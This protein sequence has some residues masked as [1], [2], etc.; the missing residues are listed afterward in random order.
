VRHRVALLAVSAA[1]AAI[2]VSSPLAASS[3]L[4]TR[5]AK[6]L[7]SPNLSLER[8]SAIAVDARTGA[9]LFAHNESAPVVPASNE[10]LPVAWAALTRLGPSYRF[11]TQVLGVGERV[12]TTWDG[13]LYLRGS[14]DPTLAAGDIGRLAA[15]VRAAGIRRVTGRI[16]GDESAFDTMR[17]VAGW[18]RY[19]V[20]LESPP[21]SALVVDRA[22]GWPGHSPPVLAAQALHDALLE[23]NVAVDGTPWFGTTPEGAELLAR[24][25]SASLAHI[26]R[27]MN[28]YSDNFT[29][30][31][32]L[33]HLGT[34]DG[35][36][37]TSA[38]GAAAVVA[39]LRAAGIPVRG[40]RIVDGS[41]L[42]SL[43]RITAVTLVGVLRAGLA[44]PRIRSAFRASFA[45]AGH[46]GTLRERLANLGAVVRGKTGTT[47]LACTLS[48]LVDDAVVFAVLQNGSPVAFWPAR[49]A[50]DKFV[51]VLA[52]SLTSRAAASPSG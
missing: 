42:S 39:E 1:I 19:F 38:R 46:S 27:T 3:D 23:R 35:R 5:L 6:T 32:L 51:T 44:N 48:G 17:S 40:V 16:L 34:L 21:L 50:Q 13:D 47:N 28:R 8:T 25:H 41:G 7:R 20:G 10:K 4:S 30:E 49:V 14:G 29:A 9:V 33:K 12:G 26:T 18:K 52:R 24:D 11:T 15:A 22:R 31:M 36:V 43:D 2:V 37:G 45:V